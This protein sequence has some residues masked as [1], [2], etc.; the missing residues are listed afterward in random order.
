MIDR[1]VFIGSRGV[2]KVVRGMGAGS[3]WVCKVGRSVFMR[4]RGAYKVVRGTGAGSRWACKVGRSV[5]MHSH[6]VYKVVRGTGVGSR[7]KN[8]Q[9][10]CNF[11][12][13]LMLCIVLYTKEISA[14]LCLVVCCAVGCS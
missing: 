3:R 4:S 11:G 12:S 1:G 2:T 6:E 7:G 8:K 13:F 10:R 5:F 9:E 14:S